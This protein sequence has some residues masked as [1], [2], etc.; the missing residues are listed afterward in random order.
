MTQSTSGRQQIAQT[1][2]FWVLFGHDFLITVHSISK[3]VTVLEMVIQVLYSLLCNP[4]DI[5]APEPQKRGSSG[6]TVV[7]TSHKWLI[8]I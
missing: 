6:P 8:S 1:C 3:E 4:L 2:L 7:H 5:F